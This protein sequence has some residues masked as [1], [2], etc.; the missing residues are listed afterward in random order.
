MLKGQSKK[1]SILETIAVFAKDNA[2]NAILMIF[3]YK[4]RGIK[5]ATS[6]EIVIYAQIIN[7]GTTYAIRRCFNYRAKRKF[8]K[9][10]KRK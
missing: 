8:T 6:L 10:N 3:A 2:T 7:L 1:E 5:I 4:Y 9:F